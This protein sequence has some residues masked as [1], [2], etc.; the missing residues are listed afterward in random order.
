MSYKVYRGRFGQHSQGGW[1]EREEVAT[2]E[3]A[4]KTAALWENKGLDVEVVSPWGET[5]YRSK[6]SASNPGAP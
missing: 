1:F 2:K 5:I 4:M 3:D 6:S